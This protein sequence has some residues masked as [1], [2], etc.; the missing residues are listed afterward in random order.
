MRQNT[1]GDTQLGIT[2]DDFLSACL[3]LYTTQGL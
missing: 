2:R 1:W 3:Q